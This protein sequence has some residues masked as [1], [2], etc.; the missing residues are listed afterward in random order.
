VTDLE[1]LGAAEREAFSVEAFGARADLSRLASMR[2]GEHAVHTWDVAVALDPSA[3]V[4]SDAVRLLVDTMPGTAGQAG[5]PAPTARTVT[6]HT[7]EPD[8][9]FALTTGPDVILS[10]AD[11]QATE[12]DLRLPAEAMV[13]LVYGRLDPAHTP[14]DVAGASLLAELRPVFPGL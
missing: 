8:S 10:P 11:E 9:R 13:R 5:R 1:Q 4:S 7:I 3:T 6:V 12:P 14:H 2:L